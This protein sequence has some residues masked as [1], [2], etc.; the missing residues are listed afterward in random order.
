VLY[1]LCPVPRQAVPRRAPRRWHRCHCGGC[2]WGRPSLSPIVT[3][4][5]RSGQ[6]P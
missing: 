1:E 4:R 5:A 6:P 2:G 3:H